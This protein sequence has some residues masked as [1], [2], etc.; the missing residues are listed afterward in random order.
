M[1]NVLLFEICA[2]CST[3]RGRLGGRLLL[4]LAQRDRHEGAIYV[5]T[6][7]LLLTVELI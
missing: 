4:S 2:F 5:K 1:N 7:D 6:V 3:L